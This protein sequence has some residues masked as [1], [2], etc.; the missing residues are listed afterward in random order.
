MAFRIEKTACILLGLGLAA[1]AQEF[2]F[3]VR[4]RHVL[5]DAQGTLRITAEGITYTESPSKRGEGHKALWGWKD[6]QQLH[7]SGDRIVL[8]TYQDTKWLLGADREYEFHA[9]QGRRFSEAYHFLAPRLDQR[10]V[11]AVADEEARPLYQ[12]PVKLLGRMWGSEGVLAIGEDRIVYKTSKRGLSRTWRY[13]D[14]E[15]ISSS[16]PFELSVTTFER[17][18]FHYGNRKAFHFQ[19]KD[20]LP[21]SRYNDLWRRLNRSKGLTLRSLGIQE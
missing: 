15:N 19:L 21:E 14:I 1:S 11:A 2:E 10:F 6:I 8:T 4:H 3:P 20:P 16:G 7:L 17:S 12:I 5:R 18:A 9:L 13:E